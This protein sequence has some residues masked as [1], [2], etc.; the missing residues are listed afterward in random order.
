MVYSDRQWRTF[1]RLLGREQEFERDPRFSNMATRTEHIEAL[2]SELA[3]LMAE[4]TTAEWLGLLQQADIP[5]M[6]LHNLES[7]LQDPHLAATGFFS[8]QDHP[9]E[10]RLRQMAVPSRWSAT[11]PRAT[12]PVPRLGEDSAAVLREHGYSDDE[13]EALKRAG[14][15]S[16]PPP[17][18]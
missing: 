10:G 5:A 8:V 2:Y 7:L 3:A 11:Q 16:T 6:P 4:R 9:S 17:G 1:F 13:I 12:R 15:T 14:V 18:A